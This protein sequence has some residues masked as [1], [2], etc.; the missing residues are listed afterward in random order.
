MGFIIGTSAEQIQDASGAAFVDSANIDFT[1]NDGANTITGDLTATAVTPGSYT[2]TSLT[3]DSKGRITAASSG[4]A[5]YTDEQAQDAV[6][7]FF[8]SNLTYTDATPLFDLSDTGVTANSYGTSLIV[9]S[10]TVDAKGRLTAA[11]SVNIATMVGDTGAGGIKGFVPAPAAG[12]AAAGKFLKADGT[13]Q[14]AG[15]SFPLLGSAGSPSAPT[16]SFSGGAG[17]SDKG[18][19]SP[20]T[21]NLAFSSGS[22]KIVEYTSTDGWWNFTVNSVGGSSPTL[23]LTSPSSLGVEFSLESGTYNYRSILRGS[24]YGDEAGALALFN[25][26]AGVYHIAHNDYGSNVIG[27]H[28]SFQDWVHLTVKPNAD[29]ASIG[30][31]AT[32]AGT[33]VT[34]SGTKFRYRLG[35][36][37]RISLDAGTTFASITAIASDTSLTTDV[38]LTGAGQPIYKR[39]MPFRVDD[40]DGIP[41]FSVNDQGILKQ[42]LAGTPARGYDLDASAITGSWGK[43]L[44]IGTPTFPNTTSAQLIDLDVNTPSAGSGANLSGL[45]VTVNSGP[46]GTDVV[47]A[48]VRIEATSNS[49]GNRLTTVSNSP[50]GIFGSIYSVR[51]TNPAGRSA[52]VLGVSHDAKNQVGGAFQAISTVAAGTAVGVQ[53]IATQDGAGSISAAVY[54]R[55]NTATS[56]TVEDSMPSVGAAGI[57][58]NGDTTSDMLRLHDNGTIAF[59][60]ADG[61]LIK[62]NQTSASGAVTPATADNKM[63]IYNASGTL[64]GYIAIFNTL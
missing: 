30:G 21:G 52:G 17:F 11:S 29:V 46:V 61:G 4:G 42:T 50:L 23:R 12:D 35:V 45:R 14:T 44:R 40:K 22:S 32:A 16:Y 1:Y 47:L 2:N 36:G 49:S 54:G 48:G 10:F 38:A 8:S 58:D 41:R 3:V 28:N 60:V 25:S 62:T 64:V 43:V 5:G 18:M 31:T 15:V 59:G 6:G 56:S 57:F 39:R 24:G 7:N 53:A 26:S 55:I 63:P 13:W 51:N 33:T 20:S 37:D 19:Y 34:G 27:R 9:S